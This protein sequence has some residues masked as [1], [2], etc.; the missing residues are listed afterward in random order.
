MLGA[1]HV[2]D[3]RRVARPGRRGGGPR[4]L[5]STAQLLG[6]ALF[7]AGL[8]LDDAPIRASGTPHVTNPTR[9][10]ARLAFAFLLTA[11]AANVGIAAAELLGHTTTL[12]QMSGARRLLAQGFLLP[13]ILVMAARILPGYSGYMLRRPR[14]LAGLV[15]SLL[16]GA[17]LRSAAEL[18]G[19]YANGWGAVVGIG[20]TIAVASFVIFAVGLWRAIDRTPYPSV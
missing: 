5:F 15:W 8:R 2:R 10:W 11:A 12:T 13:V 1:R 16:A 4:L 6:G 3:Q 7:V 20:S 14:L 19:G 9:T 17:A 18:I